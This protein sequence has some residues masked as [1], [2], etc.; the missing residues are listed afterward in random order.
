L[1]I[2]AYFVLVNDPPCPDAVVCVSIQHADFLPIHEYVLG[3]DRVFA[4]SVH[5][6]RVAVEAQQIQFVRDE[7]RVDTIAATAFV[8]LIPV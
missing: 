4:G 1:P 6:D 5:G 8:R 3:L 7:M 2:I